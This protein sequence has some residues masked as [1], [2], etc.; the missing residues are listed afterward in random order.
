MDSILTSTKK[1]L[2]ITEEYE[3]FDADIITHI[4]SVFAVLCQLGAGPA[5][6]FS[7]SGKDAVWNDF[8]PDSTQL[9]FI[10]T[11]M[12]HKVRLLFDPPSSTAVAEA[13]KNTVSELEW[14]IL[15]EAENTKEENQNG[16]L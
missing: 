16:D 12:G 13:I 8:M 10:K 11:Y 5:D 4:N 3:C 7:I 15:V 6:G 2:G 14:R 9:G 1:L